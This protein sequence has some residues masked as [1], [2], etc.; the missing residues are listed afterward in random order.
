MSIHPPKNYY[1]KASSN[2]PGIQISRRSCNWKGDN[3]SQ[4]IPSLFLIRSQIN[5]ANIRLGVPFV[6]FSSLCR[7]VNCL[8]PENTCSKQLTFVHVVF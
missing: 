3:W 8:T 2:R 6:I 5:T 1:I 7:S 4:N